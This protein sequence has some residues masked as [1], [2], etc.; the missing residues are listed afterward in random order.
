MVNVFYLASCLLGMLTL[1]FRFPAFGARRRQPWAW[2]VYASINA[3]TL[4]VMLNGRMPLAP[5]AAQVLIW[6]V[7][8][9]AVVALATPYYWRPRPSWDRALRVLGCFDIANVLAAALMTRLAAVNPAGAYWVLLYLLPTLLGTAVF[10]HRCWRVSRSWLAC[11]V[12]AFALAALG[13]RLAEAFVPT[14]PL[15]ALLGRV[16][17][18]WFD[19]WWAYLRLRPLHRALRQ[20]NPEAVLVSRRKWF[21]PHHRVR[22]AVLEL[23]EWR[24][25]LTSRF[26]PAVRDAADSLGRQAG[27]GGQELAVV[28]E[29]AQLKAALSSTATR[30]RE[31]DGAAADGTGLAEECAWW[32]AVARAYRHSP[33]VVA[34]QP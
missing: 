15:I 9:S 4:L 12:G 19:Q 30:E 18:S 17:W 32:L 13:Y 29:A 24:W 34:A 2:T 28:V 33:V 16:P 21:D 20:V 27:L 31:P 7:V 14:T 23:D 6:S 10:V 25:A 8:V 26:D 3:V 5:A 1:L 22:R 11:L